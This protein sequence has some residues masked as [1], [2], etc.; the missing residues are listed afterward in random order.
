MKGQI[1]YADQFGMNPKNYEKVMK[2]L[3]NPHGIIYISGATG[4]GKTTTLYSFLEHL[5]KKAVSIVSVEDPVERKIR[6]VAQIQVNPAAGLTFH[7]GLRAILRQDP[8]IIMVGETRD[9]ETAHISVRAAITGHL[10]LS[11]IHTNNAVSTIARLTDMGI[12]PYMVS[13]SVVGLLAQRLVRK[14]CTLCKREY[15]PDESERRIVGA[16]TGSFYKGVGCKDC[17]HTGY[18]GRIAVHEI[19]DVDAKMRSMITEKAEI[20]EIENYCIQ[21]KGMTLISK[22]IQDLVKSGTTTVSE[23]IRVAVTSD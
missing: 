13:S 16:Q 8:D 23:L 11:T 18:K 2:I 15:T 22:E 21:E 5:S 6:R 20:D 3:R 7:V 19:V 10:V 14:I 17:S 9:E 1:D 4:S 12:P